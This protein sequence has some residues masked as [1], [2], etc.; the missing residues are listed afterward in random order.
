MK[1]E[2]TL[3][4]LTLLVLLFLGT[5]IVAAEAGRTLVNAFGISAPSSTTLILGENPAG[6]SQIGGVKLQLM[7]RSVNGSGNTETKYYDGGLYA[8]N[9]VFGVGLF[10]EKSDQSG[11]EAS[12]LWGLGG[13]INTVAIGVSG[14]TT[15]GQNST[16]TTQFGLLFGSRNPLTVGATFYSDS[17]STYDFGAGFGYDFTPGAN[18][19]LDVKHKRISGEMAYAAGVR[20][21]SSA[22]ELQLGYRVLDNNDASEDHIQA[23]LAFNMTQT[24]S[25]QYLYNHFPKHMLGLTV[26]F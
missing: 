15:G 2:K 19:A 6:F 16:T 18:F 12:T 8:G 20:L 10:A 1:H 3:A 22:L 21:A 5:P 9:N 25:F 24:F 17:G 13:G 7:G 11:S 26:R 23:G 4:S 14:V